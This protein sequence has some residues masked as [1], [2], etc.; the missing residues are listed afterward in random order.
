VQGLQ[1]RSAEGVLHRDRM[2]VHRHVGEPVGNA[3][4]QQGACESEEPRLAPTRAVAPAIPSGAARTSA[5]L[6]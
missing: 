3:E 5:A 1:R 4:H 2:G 6:P